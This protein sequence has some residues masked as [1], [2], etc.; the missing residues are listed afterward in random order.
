[1]PIIVKVHVTAYREDT[2][3]HHR[4]DQVRDTFLHHAPHEDTISQNSVFLH[5]LC[6]KVF[7][8]NFAQLI[9]YVH[10]PGLI[11]MEEGFFGLCL[12]LLRG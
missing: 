4:T 5:G 6:R 3:L 2:D 10:Y 7:E 1:M 11:D 9:A 12:S 8:S